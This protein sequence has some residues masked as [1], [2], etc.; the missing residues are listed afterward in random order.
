MGNLESALAG[1]AVVVS[2]AFVHHVDTATFS[3]SVRVCNFTLGI[4][5]CNLET[6]NDGWD[7]VGVG[8]II[9]NAYVKGQNMGGVICSGWVLRID[10]LLL[11]RLVVFFDVAYQRSEVGH[12]IF[13]FSCAPFVF[14]G[15]C[16]FE[17]SI[18]G[19]ARRENETFLRS[20]VDII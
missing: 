17:T 3:F 6:G 2:A 16:S 9:C 5:G 4:T 14:A 20:Y 13:V 19:N 11:V 10:N 15:F 18:H 1:I 12:L 8:V 7:T